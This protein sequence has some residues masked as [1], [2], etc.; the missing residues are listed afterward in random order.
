VFFPYGDQYQD[1]V[2][3]YVLAPLVQILGLQKWVAR[4]PSALFYLLASTAFVVLVQAHCR[5]KWFSLVGGFMFSLLP[6]VFPI[7]RTANSGYTAML[8]G[9]I[10]GWF[11][12]LRALERQS[13]GCA[14]T[15]AAAW[16]LA[17]YSYHAGRPMAAI[18]IA[19]L[20]TAFHH[21]IITR[22]RIWLAL[23]VGCVCALVPM[24]VRLIGSLDVLTSRFQATSI[25]QDHPSPGEAA[26]RFVS[27]YVDYFSPRFLFF[28][29]DRNLRH[30]TGHGGE[31]WV[32]LVPLILVG[33][34]AVVRNLKADPSS[35]FILLGLITYPAAAALTM[36]RMHSGRSIHGVIFWAIT[37]A[38]GAHVLWRMG[39]IERTILVIACCVGMFEVV[40][41]L[42]DYFGPYQ[43]RSREAFDA[44]FT[45]VLEDCFHAAGKDETVYISSAAVQFW[46]PAVNPEFKPTVYV[47]ILFFSKINPRVYQQ[48]GI[49]KDRVCLYD[50]TISKPGLL[51][52]CNVRLVDPVLTW[53]PPSLDSG[54]VSSVAGGLSGEEEEVPTLLEF[55]MNQE[56]IPVGAELLETKPLWH[57][58]GHT[59]Q[60]EI[61][62]VK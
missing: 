2:L 55:K 27:R 56:P 5:N 13:I 47:D 48:H 15:G 31:L 54:G 42:N 11:F 1:P 60:Y 12:T 19:C 38:M 32:F 4:L 44:A 40:S 62:R 29:G 26:A 24:V 7:S 41:Y 49:P 16:A 21:T 6:W 61:Y 17:M 52:T 36:T 28:V 25:F 46:K 14:I 39:G 34:Y 51:L 23:C 53:T 8:F 9:M 57:V 18:I 43:V 33:L 58:S 50:G 10:C 22:W 45:E 3:P 30:H 20:A 35:R 37:A 59:V